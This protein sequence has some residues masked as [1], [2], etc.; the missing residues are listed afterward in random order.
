MV[1]TEMKMSFVILKMNGNLTLQMHQFLHFLE[2][3]KD[4]F[5]SGFLALCVRARVCVNCISCILFPYF[6]RTIVM[7][8]VWIGNPEL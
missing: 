6:K 4:I 3:G 8:D 2:G 5:V 1:V 7:I